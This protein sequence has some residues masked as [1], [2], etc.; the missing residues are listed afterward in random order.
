MADR[1]L[2][3]A[4][5][6]YWTADAYDG[7]ARGGALAKNGRTMLAMSGWVRRICAI[8]EKAG[9]HIITGVA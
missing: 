9:A 6:D 3:I 1:S 4:L 5:Q 7:L 2:H 8:M